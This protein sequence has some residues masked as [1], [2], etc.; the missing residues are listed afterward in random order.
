MSDQLPAIPKYGFL[1]V[2][3]RAVC[4]AAVMGLILL[5]FASDA[6]NQAVKEDSVTEIAQAVFLLAS[7]VLSLLIFKNYKVANAMGFVLGIFY[8]VLF[9]REQDAFLETHLFDKAWQAIVLILLIPLGVFLWR[10]FKLF[11]FQVY[12]MRNSL[13]IGVLTVGFIIVQLYS[14]LYGKGK[15]WEALMGEDTY[16]RRVKDAS[17]ESIELLGYAIMFVGTVELFIHARNLTISSK[18]Q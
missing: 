2:L 3:L 14:R 18:Q 10:N 15:L 5:A 11:A 9:T 17:E 1:L 7:G 12:A 4:Y 8:L 6:V 13:A 16:M